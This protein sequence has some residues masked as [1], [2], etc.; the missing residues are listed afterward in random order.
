MPKVL[1]VEVSLQSQIEE[2]REQ[3]ATLGFEL[4]SFGGGDVL[5]KSR[6]ALIPE[7][8]LEEVLRGVLESLE[9]EPGSSDQV[10][11]RSLPDLQP[12]NRMEV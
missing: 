7:A 9:E 5:I 11:E 12:P 1:Q 10:V 4:E 6:P 3:L 2:H 8:R